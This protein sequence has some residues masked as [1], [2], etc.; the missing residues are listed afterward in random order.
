MAWQID[1]SH[2]HI[3]FSIRHLKI[4]KVRGSFD[5]FSRTIE[6]DEE[7]P[8]AATADMEINAAS[9]NTKDE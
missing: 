2:S 7:Y 4:A 3:H 1:S 8:T 5:I 9:I 6:F